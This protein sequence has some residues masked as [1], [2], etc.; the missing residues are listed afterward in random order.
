M[1]L[2][3]I[4]F[5]DLVRENPMWTVQNVILF[6]ISCRFRRNL[7]NICVTV[8][9]NSRERIR[10]VQY[11]PYPNPKFCIAMNFRWFFFSSFLTCKGN[12]CLI[13]KSF[14][15][16]E[17]LA[18]KRNERQLCV[19]GWNESLDFQCSKYRISLLQKCQFIIYRG[20]FSR[21]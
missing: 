11:Y 14:N 10:D 17:R 18:D 15:K 7:G 8:W 1:K 6:L 9:S 13:C 2:H 20:I 19:G 12:L 21:K 16:F 3:S 4:S 5:N